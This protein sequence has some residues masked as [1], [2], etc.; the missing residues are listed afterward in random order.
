MFKL[1]NFGLFYMHNQPGYSFDDFIFLPHI[2]VSFFS[3]NLFFFSIP[4]VLFNYDHLCGSEFGMIPRSLLCSPWEQN[5]MQFLFHGTGLWGRIIRRKSILKS[6]PET[7]Y[8]VIQL[9]TQKR[10]KRMATYMAIQCWVKKYLV[11]HINASTKCRMPLQDCWLEW[12]QSPPKQQMFL[13]FLLV[14]HLKEL[15]SPV[16]GTRV[17]VQQLRA[18]AALAEDL[19]L[20]PRMEIIALQSPFTVVPGYPA[21]SSG[22]YGYQIFA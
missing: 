3:T 18:L 22:F 17:I 13:L 7:T 20:I 14:V 6:H 1:E 2:P 11:T 19:G 8:L 4:F 10:C 16:S 5:W 9:K 21:S 12:N 15:I